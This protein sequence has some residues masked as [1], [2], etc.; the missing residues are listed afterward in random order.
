MDAVHRPAL[1]RAKFVR[2]SFEF[3]NHAVRGACKARSNSPH[4]LIIG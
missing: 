2:S 4:K 3:R 1:K